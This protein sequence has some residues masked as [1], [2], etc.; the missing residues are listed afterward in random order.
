[1]YEIVATLQAV[2]SLSLSSLVEMSHG[3]EEQGRCRETMAVD[4][5]SF[6]RDVARV[7]DDLLCG[8]SDKAQVSIESSGL[9]VNG[10]VA[11]KID[12]W[13]KE[14]VN[15]GAVWKAFLAEE[16]VEDVK[17]AAGEKK[18]SKDKRLGG[19]RLVLPPSETAGNDRCAFLLES[20][21]QTETSLL[22][23]FV[24]NGFQVSLLLEGSKVV[25]DARLW[26]QFSRLQSYKV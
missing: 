12:N 10:F 22:L 3:T 1:M 6:D 7:W 8:V 20:W 13:F 18:V 15:E 9:R 24:G 19:L 17:D 23:I 2:P 11:E 5:E 26:C 4:F 14:E 16:C 25:W 21:V